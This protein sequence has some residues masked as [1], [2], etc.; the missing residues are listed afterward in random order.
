MPQYPH[1]SALYPS[2]RKHTFQF[3]AKDRCTIVTM[4]RTCHVYAPKTDA[5]F[6]ITHST[7]DSLVSTKKKIRRGRFN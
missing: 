4:M 5:T 2:E 1:F 3:C 6:A 7:V